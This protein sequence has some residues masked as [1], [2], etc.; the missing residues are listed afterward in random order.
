MKIKTQFLFIIQYHFILSNCCLFIKLKIAGI[1]KI[2]KM[3]KC[4]NGEE[5]YEIRFELIVHYGM[6]LCDSNLYFLI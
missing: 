2:F 4:V 1:R 6:N 3:S 5:M